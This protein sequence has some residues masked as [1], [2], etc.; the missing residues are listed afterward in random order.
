MPLSANFLL[1]TVPRW[2][3][4]GEASSSPPS[5]PER[6]VAEKNVSFHVSRSPGLKFLL[7]DARGEGFV[8]DVF[9]L[10]ASDC[11]TEATP[12]TI[13]DIGANTGYYVVRVRG[14]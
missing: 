12:A 13:V 2:S 9:R 5:G 10:L 4:A 3:W 8:K 1:D 7:T 6:H 11:A 14:S